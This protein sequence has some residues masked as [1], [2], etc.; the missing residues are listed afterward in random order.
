MQLATA[1]LVLLAPSMTHDDLTYSD[2]TTRAFSAK[3]LHFSAFSLKSAII[4][5]AHHLITNSDILSQGTTLRAI[6]ILTVS[7]CG[8]LF[9]P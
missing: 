9:L 3:G 4:L 6:F 2:T 5:P 7:D 8:T 1:R